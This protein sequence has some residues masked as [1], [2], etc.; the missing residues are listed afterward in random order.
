M[1]ITFTERDFKDGFW[2]FRHDEAFRPTGLSDPDKYSGEQKLSI[3]GAPTI[4]S[5]DQAKLTRRWIEALPSLNSVRVLWMSGKVSQLMFEAVCEMQG[6]EALWLKWSGIKSLESIVKLSEL[7]SLHVGSSSQIQSIEP[8]VQLRRLMWL[9][10]ENIKL[11]QNISPIGECSQLLGL[12]I[13]GSM[14]TTQKVTSL[15]PISNL[16]NLK[17]LSIVNLRASDK[18]LK[19]LFRLQN[20]RRFH[21]ATWWDQAEIT[22]LKRGNPH[23]ETH[24]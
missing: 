12:A 6:L 5:K 15:I 13:D 8:L 23:L 7:Q 22:E 14:W 18:T 10:L 21:A 9:E 4:S 2:Y 1:P 11:I 19:P 3:V 20:L 16:V 24:L 17:Y